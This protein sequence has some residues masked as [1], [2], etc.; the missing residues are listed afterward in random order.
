[1]IISNQVIIFQ[2]HS[3]GFLRYLIIPFGTIYTGLKVIENLNHV[4]SY[5]IHPNTWTTLESV[6]LKRKMKR[7]VR[8]PLEK[9]VKID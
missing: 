4:E 5:C 1:M 2:P 9:L 8:T 6:L 3:L 7:K